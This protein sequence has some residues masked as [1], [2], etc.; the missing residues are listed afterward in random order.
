LRD[1]GFF[2]LWV[3]VGPVAGFFLHSV[4]AGLL[5][6]NKRSKEYNSTIP[7]IIVQC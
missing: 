5:G 7:F 3:I 2:R 1:G 6:S 4:C